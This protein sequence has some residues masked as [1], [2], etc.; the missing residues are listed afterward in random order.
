MLAKQI[1]EFA[2]N[3][4][5]PS[6]CVDQ[7]VAIVIASR[8]VKAFLSASENASSILSVCTAKLCLCIEVANRAVIWSSNAFARRWA[9][10]IGVAH[11]T[12]V[13]VIAAAKRAP[14][15]NTAL[16]APWSTLLTANRVLAAP[17]LPIPTAAVVAACATEG[18][19]SRKA[20]VVAPFSSLVA[21]QHSPEDER[22]SVGSPAAR[23][24]AP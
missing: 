1:R 7:G 12:P 13:V 24:K 3:P 17:V 14:S 15:R 6:N 20:A 19:S 2:W 23:L 8:C 16:I 11:T 22:G 5:Y 18:G 4:K 9:A 21:F 10:P